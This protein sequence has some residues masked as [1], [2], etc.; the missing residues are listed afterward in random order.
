MTPD[1][2]TLVAYAASKG[3]VSWD[4][5]GRNSPFALALIDAMAMPGL[6]IGQMFRE[7]RDTV[8]AETGNRQEPYTYGS[9]SSTPFYL[10]GPEA[11]AEEEATD[12]EVPEARWARIG[13]E[14][15]AQLLAMADAGD[16]R[17]LLSL[18]YLKMYAE[19]PRGDMAAAVTYLQEA[20]AAGDP[21]AMFNLAIVYEKGRGVPADPERAL[22]LYEAS[23][24]RDYAAAINTMGFLRYSGGLGI[25][26]DRARAVDDFRRAADLR[27]PDAMFNYALMINGGRVDGQGPEAAAHY[28]Y[29]ALRAGGQRVFDQ[30][31]EHPRVLSV[32]TRRALQ[33]EL[34]GRGF[35][36][37]PIDGV[38][39]AGTQSA[40]RLAFGLDL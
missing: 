33:D 16:P 19:P 29:E 18:A 8:L 24:A 1:R 17:S 22:Q 9:L 23:A 32:A 21:E 40:I 13:P 27:W 3:Q 14:E 26:Q 35:Y 12:A 5:G 36:D 4:G 28:L 31:T 30:L 7:V 37:G 20:A 34:Q 2:G 38:Y 25:A 10:V 15:E 39:G 11:Q 6:E